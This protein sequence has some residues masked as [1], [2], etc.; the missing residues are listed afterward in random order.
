MLRGKVTV[1]QRLFYAVFHLLSGLLELHGLQFFCNGFCLFSGR[2]FAFLGVDRL[3][4]LSDLLYLGLVST[5]DALGNTTAFA[6]DGADNLTSVTFADGT[7]FAYE[8]DRVG[9]LISQTDALG[10]VTAFEYDALRQLVKTTYPDGSEATGSYDASGNLISTTDADGNTATAAYDAV[11]NLVAVTDALGNTTAYEYDK[12][13]QLTAETLAN[14][15]K[16]HYNYDNMGRVTSIVTATGETTSYTYDAADNILTVTAPDGGVTAYT[17]DSMGRLLTETAPDGAVTRYTYDLAGNV[18]TVTDALGN[19]TS[20]AFDANGNLLTV[21]DALGCVTQY[22]YDALNRV[23][24]MTDA[25]GGVTSY[26]Y[27]AVGNLVVPAYGPA[28]E[29]Y[30]QLAPDET[31]EEGEASFYPEL[32]TNRFGQ[33]EGIKGGVVSP[34]FLRRDVH[35]RSAMVTSV[36]SSDKREGSLLKKESAVTASAAQ[37]NTIKSIKQAVAGAVSKISKTKSKAAAVFNRSA[38]K[39]RTAAAQKQAAATKKTPASLASLNASHPLTKTAPSV[40]S[41]T[42]TQASCSKQETQTSWPQ[43]ALDTVKDVL[44]GAGNAFGRT[45]INGGAALVKGGGLAITY[46]YEF[47]NR[48]DKN[49]YERDRKDW[50]NY[51]DSVAGDIT[52]WLESTTRGLATNDVY[53]DG[54]QIIGDVGTLV[55]EYAAF[56]K[57]AKVVSG[58]IKGISGMMF[59]EEAASSVAVA[60]ASTVAGGVTL[61]SY[62]AIAA[63]IFLN[64]STFKNDWNTLQEDWKEAETKEAEETGG[65]PEVKNEE[66]ASGGNDSDTIPDLSNKAVKHPMND[67]MPINYA[68]Q[69]EYLDRASAEQYLRT[70]TFFS[71]DWTSEQVRNALNFGYKEAIEN[72]ITSGNYTFT[73][74]GEEVTVCLQDGVFK[75]GYGTYTFTYEELLELLEH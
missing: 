32:E 34:V 56:L 16:T 43:R 66:N 4:H 8:Y 31:D 44:L 14:G 71:E 18:S 69:L 24:S 68:K 1:G 28:F 58:A 5:T 54:G 26:E 40:K 12:T 36:E 22:E 73:Y 46:L 9:N 30:I 41:V 67:H 48:G 70:N 37:K 51:I 2:L 27:D 64:F 21:T 72:G 3:E 23:V 57:A 50:S 61:E 20:Y 10:N 33:K 17:Y 19:T 15:G 39:L 7:S 6:Y 75:T 59:T 42:G 65:E 35:V 55:A 13:G 53:Y 45:M 29:D 74:L 60:G 38:E 47:F 25:N 52:G 49:A 63:E 62:L 11:G